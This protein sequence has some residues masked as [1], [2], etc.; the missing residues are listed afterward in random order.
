MLLK[1][2]GPTATVKISRLAVDRFRKTIARLSD[3]QACH[4]NT[5]RLGGIRKLLKMKLDPPLTG[6]RIGTDWALITKCNIAGGSP[7]RRT[8]KGGS[9]LDLGKSRWYLSGEFSRSRYIG[10][11]CGCVVPVVD[12]SARSRLGVSYDRERLGQRMHRA[13]HGSKPKY[14]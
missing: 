12:E 10:K 6:I 1:H 13:A 5:T 7:A 2:G 14:G 11:G 8:I 9:C 3:G 4:Q